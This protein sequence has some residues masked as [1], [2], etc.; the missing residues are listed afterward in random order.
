MSYVRHWDKMGKAQLLLSKS[1]KL[2][3]IT[4]CKVVNERRRTVST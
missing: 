3:V 2:L 1:S 4:N